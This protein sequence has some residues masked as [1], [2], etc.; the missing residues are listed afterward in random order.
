[1]NTEFQK[2]A[3]YLAGMFNQYKKRTESDTDVVK[4]KA[5]LD[6]VLPDKSTELQNAFETQF[7]T[8][9]PIS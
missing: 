4:I 8:L 9:F 3:E 6:S 5:I 2:L 7:P 1:M